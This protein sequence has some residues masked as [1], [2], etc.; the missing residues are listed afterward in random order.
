MKKIFL[1]IVFLFLA[2][3]LCAGNYSGGTGTTNDPYIISKVDDLIELSI[4]SNDWGKHFRQVNDISFNENEQNVDWDGDGSATWDTEDQKGFI[5]IGI[6]NWSSGGFLP[7]A[8][9]PEFT[10]S[11][12]GSGHTINNLYI[13][14]SEYDFVGMFGCARGD[15]IDSIGLTNVNISGDWC[16]GALVGANYAKIQNC[17]STGFVAGNTYVGGLTGSNARAYAY[18]NNSY[19]RCTVTGNNRVGGLIGDVYNFSVLNCFSTG[20]VT[21]S[22]NVGGFIGSERVTGSVLNSFW[23]IN[24]SGQTVS[25]GGIGKTTSEMKNVATYT[26]ETKIGLITAWDFVTNPYD[27]IDDNNYWD[28][29]QT[30][31]INDGYPILSW[32]TLSDNPLPVELS[33]FRGK[34][35]PNGVELYWITQSENNNAGFVLLR[36]SMEIASYE[37]TEAL[38]GRSTTSQKHTYTFTDADVNLEEIYTY[39][40][41]S[42]DYSGTRHSY[43]QLVEVKVVGAINNN[44]P[45]DYALEQNYPNPFNPST[46]ISFTMK[47]AGVATLKVY[48]MLGRNVFEKQIPATGGN[49]TEVFNA[50]N[51]TS[52][53]YFYQ[54]STESFNKTM[55]MILVK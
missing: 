26:D 19:S 42:V 14:R 39:K 21:G 37:N 3:K 27:D 35:T 36:N 50:K 45:L 16:V 30:G 12:R 10:G 1:I 6:P 17:F 38:V 20:F 4:T 43:S 54:L 28:I 44:K 5:P 47:I 13:N 33:K 34:S 29:D 22:T 51:L 31:T 9:G 55:K 52:G 15:I 8:D 7:E 48:D 24:T 53:V 41:V 25:A 2:G 49:N 11:Y 46:T 32:Q 23:D 18:M 40:L